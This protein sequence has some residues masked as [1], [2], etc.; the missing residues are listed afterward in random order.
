MILIALIANRARYLARNRSKT[1]PVFR[2]IFCSNIC[3]LFCHG[4]ESFLN[5]FIL[6]P[7]DFFWCSKLELPMFQKEIS[8]T[9][10]E[11]SSDFFLILKS[12][13]LQELFKET[14]SI[15]IMWKSSYDSLHAELDHVIYHMLRNLTRFQCH[16]RTHGKWRHLKELKYLELMIEQIRSDRR[17]DMCII[18]CIW[19][20][21]FKGVIS[22]L[23]NNEYLRVRLSSRIQNF[24]WRWLP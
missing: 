7:F 4:K 13:R 19:N 16:G 24:V 15:N 21:G 1:K 14:V 2:I 9:G 18:T 12:S 23:E 5:C 8:L 22:M 17:I 10:L 20:A 11:Q 3:W 6:K